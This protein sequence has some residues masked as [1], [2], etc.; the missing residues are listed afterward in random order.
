MAENMETKIGN[1]TASRDALAQEQCERALL[2]E[3]IGDYEGARRE[4]EG[5]WHR[6]GERPAVEGLG[7]EAAAEVLLCAATLT[8][9]IGSSAQIEGAQE[10]AKNLAS[11]AAAIFR[12]L[13]NER[14]EAQAQI[15][16]AHCYWREA[17][18]D[19]ARIVLNDVLDRADDDIE[20]KAAATLRLAVVESSDNK[21][22]D[23]LAF[24]NRGLPLAESLRSHLLCGLYRN[25]MAIALKN[26]YVSD[27]KV[28]RLDQAL[29]EYTAASYHFEIAGHERYRARVEN[30]LGFLLQKFARYDEAHDHLAR[31][32]RLFMSLKDTGSV[33]QV[34][35]TRARVLIAQG[36]FS[37]A[38]KVIKT[39]VYSLDKGDES[40]LLAEALT[41][42]GV[43]LARLGRAGDSYVSLRRAA[44]CAAQAGDKNGAGL[45]LITSIE[46]LPDFLSRDEL[47][48]T[49][50]LADEMLSSC[51]DGDT[52]AR[53]RA[54]ARVA[55]KPTAKRAEEAK[56]AAEGFVHSDERTAQLL[57][58]ARRAA[59]TSRPV[60]ITGETGTGK[61]ALARLI[62]TW[63]GRK[64]KFVAIN[65]AAI[66]DTL[67]ESQ[68]FGHV[69]GAFTDA[70]RDNPGAVREAAGGTLFLD[71]IGEVSDRI[72][73]KLLRLIELG[74]ILPVGASAPVR[75][76]VRIVAATNRQL[77]KLLQ[78]GTFTFRKDLYYRLM[79]FEVRLPP[80]RERPLDA[81]ALA[82]HFIAEQSA[83][84]GKDVRFAED[85]V[86]ALASLPLQGNARELRAIIE[87]LMLAAEDGDTVTI[88]SLDEFRP[89]TIIEPRQPEF[90]PPG[91][92]L[93]NAVHE[94]ERRL[95]V[96]ALTQTKGVVSQA[97]RLLGY[98]NHQ[99]LVAMLNM[100][101]KDLL[102]ARSPILPRHKSIIKK[103]SRQ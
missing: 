40:A 71:E 97:A 23:A 77:S 63:S 21:A 35:D 64:G 74:E 28:E 83:Q 67:I 94:Y 93:R 12:T 3:K 13:R 10:A 54:A 52:L 41:T 26:L 91:F 7:R 15:E 16:M 69:R 66:S 25:E 50:R 9:R 45:A 99:T 49:Y 39:A 101:H 4:M 102:P 81:L 29:I 55:L 43:A 95:L 65:C 62:H 92:D 46:E 70:H 37:E 22:A 56:P 100:R 79:T 59:G 1:A 103:G 57:A 47:Q 90:I 42:R 24:L 84:Y 48:E 36:K 2:R 87:R 61:E 72:Q 38:L 73:A 5:L 34:D 32:R 19:E 98:K 58:Y 75:V 27:G 14:G 31:A 53:L 78:D 11:E 82:R 33:A 51:K 76:D 86:A 20:V 80:L 17:A 96:L 30:N 18:F 89:E 88:D 68:L 60:V 85:A 8:G 6:V 44:S